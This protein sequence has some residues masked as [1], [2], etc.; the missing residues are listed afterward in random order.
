MKIQSLKRYVKADVFISRGW[1][2]NERKVNNVGKS[3]Q[4][5][6]KGFSAFHAMVEKFPTLMLLPTVISAVLDTS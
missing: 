1:P 5:E 3:R 6:Q 2:E 4:H